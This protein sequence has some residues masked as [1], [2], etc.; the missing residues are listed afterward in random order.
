MK[1]DF[2]NFIEENQL[3]KPNSKLLLAISGGIDSMVMLYLFHQCGYNFSV[4]HCNFGLRG[5]E[6]DEDE[7]LVKNTC[8]ELGIQI[9]TKKINTSEYATT[10]NISIQV[11]A[12]NLRYNW[13]KE[14]CIENG[15]DAV[16]VAHNKNDV[17]ETM[18]INL[19]RGT[20]LKGLTGIKPISNG[21]IRPLIF[22]ERKEIEKFAIKKCIVYRNDSSNQSTKY[23]RNRIRHNVLPEFEQINEGIIDN[24]YKTSLYLDNAWQ[25]I[26][27]MS[28]NFRKEVRSDYDSE[29]HYSIRLL[30]GFAFRQIFL[31]EELT[32]YGFPPSMILEI[33]KSLFKQ[34]GKIFYSPNYKLIRD[35]DSLIIT[36]I[37]ILE[38]PQI[39]INKNDRILNSIFSVSVDLFENSDFQIPRDKNIGSFDYSKLVF[40]LL[41]R[42]WNEGD[43]FIPFGMKGR[44]KVSDFLIDQKV[45]LHQKSRIYILESNNEIIWIVGYRIDNRYRID[46][47]TTKIITVKV[48]KNT[49]N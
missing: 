15:L 35:R 14:L 34:S 45:P 32:G 23:A 3:I 13:F 43:W 17:A 6:S 47:S 8:K 21:I 31:V 41:L 20:G 22:A 36:K 46:D 26:D 48:I 25:V 10:E 1:K 24:L 7:Q 30:K 28:N 42:P 27:N 5:K 2:K 38:L 44:K 16:A 12:R 40:P 33:E 9:Y 39:Y 19:C 29:I 11:A 4:A 49:E 37:N 18:L